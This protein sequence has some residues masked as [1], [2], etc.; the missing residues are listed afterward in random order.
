MN[1][2]RPSAEC[3]SFEELAALLDDR[4]DDADAA[5]VRD[6]LDR[7]A[8][9][10]ELFV[11]TAETEAD[12][13]REARESGPGRSG[14]VVG[15]FRRLPAGRVAAVAA[16]LAVALAALL[17]YPFLATPSGVDE[18]ASR[19]AADELAGPAFDPRDWGTLRGADDLS[20]EER[21]QLFRIGV[22]LADLEVALRRGD[23][24]T[25]AALLG[26]VGE[27]FDDVDFGET[28]RDA[29]REL[30]A[31]TAAGLPVA[32][33]RE[34]ARELLAEV[35]SFL[36]QDPPL[37]DFGFAAE[38]ARLAAA[39]GDVTATERWLRLMIAAAEESEE[40]ATIAALEVGRE[41]PPATWQAE[42]HA[43][44]AQRGHV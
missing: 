8:D 38:A 28:L 44:I 42:L 27:R 43:L 34:R 5:R 3:P 17:L 39:E 11:M 22:L 35:A 40:D 19:M 21:T 15:F 4:L 26:E 29:Y 20:A 30:G 10:Y 2:Q 36:E 41:R 12:L 24:A 9:C 31:E 7:C 33:T 25:I 18:L 13:A 14:T 16:V 6:H 1:V 37:L 23:R 32:E